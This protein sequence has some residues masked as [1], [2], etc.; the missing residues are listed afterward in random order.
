M[1]VTTT[2][3]LAAIVLS[4]AGC[5]GGDDGGD[6]DGALSRTGFAQ[7]ANGLCKEAR[8]D[9]QT[10]LSGIDPDAPGPEQAEQLAEIIDIDETL[11]EDVDDLVPP[12]AAQDTVDQLLDAW[13]ERIDLEEQLREATANDDAGEISALQT[14]VQQVDARANPIAGGLLLNECTRGETVSV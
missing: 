1:R 4:L 8:A 12:D 5:D 13:R 7:T 14:Q 10:V 9:R 11:L 3:V 2:A 6:G